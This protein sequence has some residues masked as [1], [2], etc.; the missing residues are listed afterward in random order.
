[1]NFKRILISLMVCVA[2][3][4]S[5]AQKINYTI[6]DLQTVGKDKYVPFW[7]HSNQNGLIPVKS[8]NVFY[9]G[10]QKKYEKENPNEWQWSSGIDGAYSSEYDKNVILNQYYASL[11]YK[12]IQILAGA[13]NPVI[14]Y[15]GL[16]FSNGNLI[17]SSNAR[18]YPKLEI[19]ST[20]YLNVPFTKGW[21]SVKGVLSNGWFLDDRYV[22]DVMLHHKNAYIRFGKSRG[23][24]FEFGI[25]HYVQWGGFSPVYGQLENDIKAFGKIFFAKP[26]KVLESDSGSSHNESDNSLGNHIGQNL[27]KLNYVTD[28]YEVS[29]SAK[30]MFEDRSGMIKK[31][32]NIRDINYGLY[33]KLNKCKLISSFLVEYYSSLHQGSVEV[34][35]NLSVIGYDSYFNNGIYRSGWSNYQR[36]FGIPINTPTIIN[37]DHSISF[38]NTTFKVFNV[39]FAGSLDWLQYKFKFTWYKNYGQVYP[40]VE[41]RSIPVD[42]WVFLRKYTVEPQQFQ[43]HYL[44]ELKFPAKKL[45]FDIIASFAYDHGDM[46]KN[47]FGCMLKLSRSGILNDLISKKH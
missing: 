34:T 45:P 17:M 14:E 33:L 32:K 13:I 1:M 24:S 15:D 22:D 35:D 20:G 47:N 38:N 44:L 21:V 7:I 42:D 5:Q 12:K 23:F 18:N 4:S 40:V 46:Y 36:G 26:G 19:G 27:I 11:R 10:L 37:D 16:S 41:D 29:V 8:A 31:F 39:G 6:E 25:E 9:L 2:G 3:L 28:D 43:R 30:N